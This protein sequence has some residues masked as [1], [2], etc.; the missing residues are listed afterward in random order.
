MW[1][2]SYLVIQKVLTHLKKLFFSKNTAFLHML[3]RLFFVQVEYFWQFSHNFLSIWFFWG[4]YLEVSVSGRFYAKWL[5]FLHSFNMFPPHFFEKITG[6]FY[7]KIKLLVFHNVSLQEWSTNRVQQQE[8]IKDIQK[9]KYQNINTRI[10]IRKKHNRLVAPQGRRLVF[11]YFLI[12]LPS[13]P[14]YFWHKWSKFEM[15]PNFLKLL[16][17]F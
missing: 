11:R 7:H 3:F 16:P 14:H 13:I 6:K 8:L 12:L 15:I 5:R 2:T 1:S 17:L 4:K 9:N 10:S